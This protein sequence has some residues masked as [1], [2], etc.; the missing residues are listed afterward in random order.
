MPVE[1]RPDFLERGVCAVGRREAVGD[2]EAGEAV[3]GPS[4]LRRAFST[5][6]SLAFG[7]VGAFGRA[8]ALAVSFAALFAAACGNSL[9]FSLSFGVAESESGIE[10]RHKAE[11]LL[12]A[13]VAVSS[14]PFG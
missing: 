12:E 14:E 8:L 6:F 13:A 7:V 1:T 5:A 3:G 2:L 9:P 11:D 10:P 4:K